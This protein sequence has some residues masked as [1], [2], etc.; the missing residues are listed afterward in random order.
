MVT[1]KLPMIIA[2]LKD[3]EKAISS[4][5]KHTQFI[6]STNT[7]LYHILENRIEKKRTL[8]NGELFH[9]HIPNLNETF[10]KAMFLKKGQPYFSFNLNKNTDIKYTINTDQVPVTIET[11]IKKTK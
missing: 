6:I 11:F 4:R 10:L 2:D 7:G 9:F 5:H 1:E 3:I 8:P